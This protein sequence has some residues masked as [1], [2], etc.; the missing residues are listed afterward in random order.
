MDVYVISIYIY[1]YI[2]IC[3]YTLY[4]YIDMCISS[5]R[6]SGCPASSPP[7]WAA[8]PWARAGG[9]CRL[10]C[11]MMCHDIYIY[12]YICIHIY[13]YMY[14]CIYV[15]CNITYYTIP[16]KNA[17]RGRRRRGLRAASCSKYQH[18]A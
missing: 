12:I 4:I 8:S 3:I 15:Y 9:G 11:A 5:R 7:P 10:D 6:P 16:S 14:V 1:I 17:S 18:V 2:Y 13:T